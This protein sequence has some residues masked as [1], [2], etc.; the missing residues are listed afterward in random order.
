MAY[1]AIAEAVR[2][3][4]GV[5][6]FTDTSYGHRLPGLLQRPVATEPGCLRP[7]RWSADQFDDY[8]GSSYV[9]YDARADID[10]IQRIEIMPTSRLRPC[11]TGPLRRH[12][13]GHARM[14]RRADA[15]RGRRLDG[16]ATAFGH[17][18]ATAQLRVSDESG[19]PIPQS[20][21][22]G[23][24][25]RLL[26]PR[27]TRAILRLA[28]ARTGSTGSRRRR[29]RRRVSVQGPLTLQ[30]LPDV[31]RQDAAVGQVRDDL[32]RSTRAFHRHTRPARARATSPHHLEA[33][34]A[35]QTARHLDLY[36]STSSSRTRLGRGG[37]CARDLP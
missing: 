28:E 34:P 37:R 33:H 13:P 23:N 32:R 9:R 1:P 12:Q 4:H 16:G 20:R 31:A 8:V 14:R 7:R 36:D 29:L 19:A 11:G 10:V 15:R 30:W 35:S 6:L 21:W 5:F 25:S 2:G 27:S 17:A 26:L 24:R 22:P 18:R 3:V